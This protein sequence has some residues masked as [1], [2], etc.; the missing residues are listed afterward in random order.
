MNVWQKW[1]RKGETLRTEIKSSPFR[2][3]D[4]ATDG[5]QVQA[6]SKNGRRVLL[7]YDHLDALWIS[8][9]LVST[10][11][12]KGGAVSK[13]ALTATVNRIW[14]Q[15]RLRAD[16]TNESQYWALICEGVR[17]QYPEGPLGSDVD[18][19]AVEG[20]PR[21]VTHLRR[22]RAPD[23]VAKKKAAVLKIAGRLACEACGFDFAEQ[24]PSLGISF[25]EVHHTRALGKGIGTRITKLS[26][27]AVLCANCHR[28][29]HRTVPMDSV[30]SFRKR[31]NGAG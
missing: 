26:D 1:F 10:A 14:K 11:I 7:S 16:H 3:L 6:P 17:R 29:I 31:L 5:I 23:L 22:E 24:Y 4:I 20:E 30:E 28:M 9:N 19:E 13:K 18:L 15:Q 12:R 2:I 21:L 25:C 8:R 27:L